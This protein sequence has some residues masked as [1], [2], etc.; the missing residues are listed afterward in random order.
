M[1]MNVENIRV[2][3][4]LLLSCFTTGLGTSTVLAHLHAVCDLVNHAYMTDL[5]LVCSA[6]SYTL[7]ASIII[8]HKKSQNCTM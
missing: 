7:S 3:S 1:I 6:T 4:M 8:I 5:S 2:S